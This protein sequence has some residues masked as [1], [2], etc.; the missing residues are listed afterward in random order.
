MGLRSPFKRYGVASSSDQS[1]FGVFDGIMVWTK[2]F[3]CSFHTWICL[4]KYNLRYQF[5]TH[6]NESTLFEDVFLMINK[7]K[8][9]FLGCLIFSIGCAK[10]APV[11]FDSP[12]VPKNYGAL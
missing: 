9:T 8:I 12:H 3:F 10:Y 7:I 4:W 11:Q 6:Y 1:C 5:S 2:N